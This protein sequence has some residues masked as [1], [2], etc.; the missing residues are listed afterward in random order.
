MTYKQFKAI[1]E[2]SERVANTAN[3]TETNIHPTDIVHDI[4]GILTGDEH[5]LPRL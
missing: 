1:Q 4:S 5:F 2:W 3:D